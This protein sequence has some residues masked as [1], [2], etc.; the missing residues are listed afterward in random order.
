MLRPTFQTC[1]NTL[2]GAADRILAMAETQQQHRHEQQSVRLRSDE[3]RESRGQWIAFAVVLAGIIAGTTLVL[4]DKSIEGV[5]TAL[6]AIGGVAGLFV[7]SRRHR[8]GA[9]PV[10]TPRP[11]EQLARPPTLPE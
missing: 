6:G 10:G 8:S 1:E 11:A 7:W 2:P 5:A 9:P 4:F 3:S